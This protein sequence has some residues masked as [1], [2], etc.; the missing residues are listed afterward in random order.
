MRALRAFFSGL[1]IVLLTVVILRA[2]W[3]RESEKMR[4]LRPLADDRIGEWP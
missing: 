4:S 2:P 3:L 1:V